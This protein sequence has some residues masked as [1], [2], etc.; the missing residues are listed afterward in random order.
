MCNGKLCWESVDELYGYH[1]EADT[2]IA[3]H[4]KHADFNDPGEIVVPANDTDV[5][6]ILLANI[7]LFSF[8]VWYESGLD[9]NNIREYLSITK[10]NQKMENPEAWI[11]LYSFLGNVY[12]PTFYGKR[13]VRPINLALK[14]TT[15]V[16][17]FSSLVSIPLEQQIFEEVERYVC[18]MYGF[19]RTCKI[20][21][22]IKS[23]FEEKSKPTI[24]SRPLGNIKSID[25]TMFLPRRVI[26]E[27]QTKR[28][29]FIAIFTREQLWHTQ[30]STILLLIL[31]GN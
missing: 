23:M 31:V 20:N 16:N 28:V 17:V 13:K 8:E 7:N 22:V 3:F 30:P 6:I 9:Y 1:L 26:L 10:L 14:D 5:A 12:P 4:E 18:I 27:Q 11:G 21:D 15:F 29:W 24:S 19:K 2:R 25:R